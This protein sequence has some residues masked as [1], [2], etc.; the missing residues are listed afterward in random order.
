MYKK[1][2]YTK[3]IICINEKKL[4]SKAYRFLWGH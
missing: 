3:N 4:F 2:I 1:E